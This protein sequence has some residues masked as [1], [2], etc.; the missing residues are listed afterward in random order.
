[1]GSGRDKK[2]KKKEEKKG[3]PSM[4]AKNKA[5]EEQKKVKKQAKKAKN[6]IAEPEED[7]D[8]ILADFQKEQEQLYK[9]TEESNASPPTRRANCSFVVNPLN[10]NELLLFGGE[11]FDGQKVHM[12]NEFYSYDDLWVFDTQ[13]Y[14]W[15]KVDVPEPKPSA[16]SGFQFFASGDSIVLYGGYSRV[17]AKGQKPVSI[18]HQDVW[19]LKMSTDLKAIRWDRKKKPGGIAPTQRSGSTIIVHKGKGILFGGVSDVNES[20]EKIESVCHNDAYQYGIDANRWYP[21]NLRGTSGK[22]KKK[23]RKG[24][25]KSSNRNDQSDE[26]SDNENDNTKAQ[27]SDDPDASDVDDAPRQT[28]ATQNIPTAA[29]MATEPFARQAMR[30]LRFNAMMTVAKNT[31]YIYGGI[32]EQGPR[33]FTLSDL[34]SL[35]LDKLDQWNCIIPDDMTTAKWLGEESDDDDDDDDENNASEED[36]DE[37]EEGNEDDE[38]AED[39]IE[40]LDVKEEDEIRRIKT[41]YP[42]PGREGNEVEPPAKVA[43]EDDP[44]TFLGAEEVGIWRASWRASKKDVRT[45]PFVLQ[46]LEKAQADPLP[47]D[48]HWQIKLQEESNDLTGKALRRDAFALAQE[49][50]NQMQPQL[51]ELKKH[52]EENEA[53][54]LKVAAKGKE[55]AADRMMSRN[56]R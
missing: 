53:E 7:I 8:A 28:G 33:E 6:D 43:D 48:V 31:L 3:G 38:E 35:N 17:T 42:K 23:R 37:E 20:E 13:E 1:M 26:G 34:W 32:F 5:K 10:P 9:V 56:R 27:D 45:D 49:H 4:G 46:R 11:Y 39:Q 47:G 29:A 50:F 18:V 19:V 44:N 25:K 30:N 12:F 16:R 22:G 36:N 41:K 54:L 55:Q 2:K 14:K 24:P 21:L 51:E 52:M 40:A 15:E